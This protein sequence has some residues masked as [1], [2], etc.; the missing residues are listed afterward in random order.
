MRSCRSG[1]YT[2]AMTWHFSILIPIL[3]QGL[4]VR[5][6]LRTTQARHDR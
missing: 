6:A 3:E 2:A 1:I 4:C 5:E